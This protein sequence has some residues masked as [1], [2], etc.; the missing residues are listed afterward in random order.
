MVESFEGFSVGGSDESGTNVLCFPF[1]MHGT[2]VVTH[3]QS[4]PFHISFSL[5]LDCCVKQ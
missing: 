1:L 5:A 2:T 3:K 4:Y